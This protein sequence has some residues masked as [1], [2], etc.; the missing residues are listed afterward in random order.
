[1]AYQVG[2]DLG[3][4][5]V[6]AAVRRPDGTAHVVPSEGGAGAAASA[7]YLGADG[8]L[9]VGDAAERRALSDPGRVVRELTRRVGDATPLLVGREPVGA[10]ELAARVLARLVDDVARREGGVATRVAVTH[11]GAWGPHRVGSLRAALAEQGLGSAVLVPEPVAAAAAYAAT[12]HVAPGATVGLHDLGGGRFEAS[13]VRSGPGGLEL[14]ATSEEIERSGGAELD[15]VVF[16]HVRTALGAAWDALDPT[17]PEVLAAVADLRRACTAA[18]EALSRDTEV[19]VPVAVPG[20]RTQVRLGRA[21]FEEAIRPTVAE[22]VEAMRRAM[23]VAGTTPAELAALVLVGGSA[24]VPLVPQ[25]LGEAFGREVTV[26]ADPVAAVAVGA[27]LL[28][29]AAGGRRPAAGSGPGG[30]GGAGAAGPPDGGRAA[31]PSG[32]NAALG[33][34]DVPNAPFAPPAAGGADGAGGGT[35]V[36]AV[37]R[38][39][40][41]ARPFTAGSGGAPSRPRRIALLASAAALGLALLGGV[42]AFGAGRLG[43]GTEAGA[44]TPVPVVDAGVPASVAG[45]ATA[46]PPGSSAAPGAPARVGPPP[47]SPR[48]RQAP[49]PAPTTSAPPAGRAPTGSAP[50]DEPAESTPAPPPA[51]TGGGA[52]DGGADDGGAGDGGAG[53]GEGNGGGNDGGNDEGGGSGAGT[54]ADAEVG[55][56]GAGGGAPPAAAPANGAAG[57]RAAREDPA[58]G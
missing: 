30:A 5:S 38:P 16:A 29:G 10:A 2:I 45:S 4:S 11:P 31:A 7:V 6:V 56:T 22:T 13:V 58:D 18:K 57:G 24:R 27:A 34:S 32:A 36:L 50:P 26:V 49:P 23:D 55:G 19:L 54:G 25:L 20:V 14:A 53:D 39:P 40:K 43:A 33:K 51:P 37:A 48:A 3:T 42:V 28:A 35:E 21:E 1:M 15:E 9:L 41:Q 12:A 44:Q 47:P 52:G 17:D 8:T 46:P